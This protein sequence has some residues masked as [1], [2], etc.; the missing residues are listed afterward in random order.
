MPDTPRKRAAGGGRKP[1]APGGTVKVAI[2]V[3]VAD[4]MYLRTLDQRLSVAVRKAIDIARKTQEGN[5]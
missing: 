5:E 4:L 2:T 1:I 3:T